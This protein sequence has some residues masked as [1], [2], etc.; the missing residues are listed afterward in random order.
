MNRIFLFKFPCLWVFFGACCFFLSNAKAT[1]Y[2][3][4]PVVKDDPFNVV[5]FKPGEKDNTFWLF[6]RLFAQAVAE[7]LNIELETVEID[8]DMRN[9][10]MFAEVL[11]SN[12]DKQDPPDFVVSV[13]YAGGE[14]ELIKKL[15]DMDIPFITVN[16]S[17]DESVWAILGK[18]GEQYK[19]WKAHL[20]PNEIEAA[21]MLLEDMT[22]LSGY[23]SVLAI[24]GSTQSAVNH[25][26]IKGLSEKAKLLRLNL[27]PPIFTDWSKADAFRVART[28]FKRVEHV[29]MVWTAGPEIASAVSDL[30]QQNDVYK[31]QG[32]VIGTFDW[33]MP[34]IELVKSGTVQ[35]SY[36]GHFMEAGWALV[37]LHDYLRGGKFSE[38]IGTVISSKLRR[39]DKSNVT[40]IEAF[41]NN[42]NWHDIDFRQYS[43]CHNTTLKKYKFELK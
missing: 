3:C 32:I 36:G 41:M 21:G 17:I 23:K 29:D 33:S 9:R 19:N 35:V 40:S 6:N 4:A 27:A 2:L 15:N 10:I 38:D 11:D 14:P 1:G 30:I 28:L 8:K 18:P 42:K 37:L 13:L 31:K 7:D 12:I 43:R 26:R 39:M 34:A 22:G 5:Y 20:S 16:T 25:Q 24:A